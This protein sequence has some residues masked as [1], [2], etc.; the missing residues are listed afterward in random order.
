MT[1]LDSRELVTPPGTSGPFR[2]SVRSIRGGLSVQLEG[3]AEGVLF[4]MPD[5]TPDGLW[6]VGVA[7]GTAVLWEE[8]G[9]APL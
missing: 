5:F 7:P 1:E 4:P 8:L 9:L 3:E 6:G 2:I